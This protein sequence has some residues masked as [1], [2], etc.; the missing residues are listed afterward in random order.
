[1]YL[2]AQAGRLTRLTLESTRDFRVARHSPLIGAAYGVY[3][4][5][6]KRTSICVMTSCPSRAKTSIRGELGRG[7][8]GRGGEGQLEKD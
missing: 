7:W 8:V 5:F 2:A 3:F 1:M 4:Y 6:K